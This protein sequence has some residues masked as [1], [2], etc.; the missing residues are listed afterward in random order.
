VADTFRAYRPWFW[1]AI[2]YNLTW[3]VSVILYPRWFLW[4][5]N[6]G[7]AS[8]PLAQGIGMMVAVYAFGYYLLARDPER[9]A[10]FIWIALAGKTF[11]AGYVSCVLSG[12]LPWRF[13]VN[14]V[15]NDLVWLPAFLTFA[16]RH[17]RRPAFH[18]ETPGS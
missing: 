1:A 8:A 3:G 17:A 16:L 13:G 12:A 4:F 6:A 18:L 15:M 2:V 10:P 9:Y 11:G 7:D 5:A 14:T